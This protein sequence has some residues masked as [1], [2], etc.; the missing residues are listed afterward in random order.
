MKSKGMTVIIHCCI[1]NNMNA[2]KNKTY[3][4]DKSKFIPHIINDT[5]VIDT[6]S[7]DDLNVAID[8]VKRQGINL[9]LISGGDGTVQSAITELIR[10]LPAGKL[11][12]ILPLRGGTMNMVANNLGIRKSPVD[13]VKLLM[14]HFDA[15]NRGQEQLSTFPLKVLKIT[16][17]DRGVRYGFTFSNGIVYKVQKAYYATGKPSFQTAANMVTTII[18]GYIIGLPSARK[19]FEKIK[20]RIEIDG[21]PYPHDRTLL[22][23]ASVLKKLVLWFKPFYEPDKKGMDQFYFLAISTDSFTLI[24]NVRAFSTGRL[25]HKN[26][27]NGITGRVTISSDSGYGI[28]GELTDDG[29]TNITIEEGPVV[30]FL[31]VPEY[32]RTNM[33]GITPRHW[34]NNELIVNHNNEHPSFN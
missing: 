34:L 4:Y 5:L 30:N 15:Y 33:L 32:I 20:A 27:F 22:S 6:Y 16:D 21:S 24:T 1:I 9:L 12:V 18:G 2:S 29:P 25:R 31:V 26:A 11:P 10:Q 14:K 7:L 28:D 13:T 8:I 19:Y 3:S 17:A 23:V